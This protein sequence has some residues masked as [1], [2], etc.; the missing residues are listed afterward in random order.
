MWIRPWARSSSAAGHSDELERLIFIKE[1][2]RRTNDV[3]ED[4]A[5]TFLEG[6][7]LG[8]CERTRYGYNRL[9]KGLPEEARARML[10]AAR[11]RK[12]SAEREIAF[13]LSK[14]SR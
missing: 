10:K 14:D 5:R 8:H 12:A 11:G 7:Y 2:A 6:T 3:L 13:L 4:E 9:R 1:R